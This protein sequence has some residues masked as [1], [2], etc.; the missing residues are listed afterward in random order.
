MPSA[1]HLVNMSTKPKYTW[2]R[3]WSATD[4]K[5]L[6]SFASAV[7]TAAFAIGHEE[8]YGL[9]N[10]RARRLNESVNIAGTSGKRAVEKTARSRYIVRGVEPY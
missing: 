1:A 2:P 9:D 7:A 5:A 10:V 6:V 4:D 3:A 8:I